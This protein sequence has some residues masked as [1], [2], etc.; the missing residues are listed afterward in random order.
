LSSV[1]LTDEEL[2]AADCL[3]IVTDHSEIDY[4]R[5]CSLAPLIVDTRN[6]LNG[7]LRRDSKARIIRL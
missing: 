6:A 1:P 7:D 2:R 5:V 3:I 4:K